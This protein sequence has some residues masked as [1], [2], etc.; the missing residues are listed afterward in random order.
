MQRVQSF[1]FI[2][3]DGRNVRVDFKNI[4]YIEA[5]NNYTRLV[6]TEKSV[7][8]LTI[9]KQWEKILPPELFCRIHRG[10]IVS[11]ERIISFDN[12]FAY[13]PG[14]NIPIGEQFK[15]A[16]PATV[17]VVACDPARKEMVP[18]LQDY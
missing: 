4:L 7:M 13:L 1:F 14:I 9:L 5:R 11:I 17:T 15:N 16:L 18:D 3:Q 6:M 12:K 8:V 10:Y 2:R